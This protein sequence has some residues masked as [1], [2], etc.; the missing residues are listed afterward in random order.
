MAVRASSVTDNIRIAQYHDAVQLP[1]LTTRSIKSKDK[2][3]A[4][5]CPDNLAPMEDRMRLIHFHFFFTFFFI[6]N[7]F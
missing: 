4:L 3:Q 6:K 5:R 1:S 7:T 2:K